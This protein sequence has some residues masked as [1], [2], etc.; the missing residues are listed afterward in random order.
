MRCRKKHVGC[1]RE[2]VH[3]SCSHSYVFSVWVAYT[4]SANIFASSRRGSGGINSE[5]EGKEMNAE[6]KE[7]EIR[8]TF[9]CRLRTD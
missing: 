7:Q 5:A 8:I 4:S 6:G 2:Q 1:V 3:L 9:Y